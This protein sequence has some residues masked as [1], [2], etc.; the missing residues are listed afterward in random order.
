MLLIGAKLNTKEC[1]AM[2]T[3]IIGQPKIDPARY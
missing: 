3:K 1:L 2:V